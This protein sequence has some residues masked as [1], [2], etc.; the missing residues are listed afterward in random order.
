MC[1]NNNKCYT[2]YFLSD[3]Y[4]K[5]F[6]F[7]YFQIHHF[8]YNIPIY[9]IAINTKDNY[10]CVGQNIL[11]KQ[12]KQHTHGEMQIA[13]PNLNTCVRLAQDIILII[14]KYY[15]RQTYLF[16]NLTS[17]QLH[18]VLYQI[19]FVKFSYIFHK[20]IVVHVKLFL[21]GFLYMSCVT[22]QNTSSR[23]YV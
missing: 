18:V 5:P 6:F 14:R 23:C 16:F 3:T 20:L 21:S 22:L 10:T 17:E 13:L 19:I 12:Q 8:G 4:V 2:C 11:I 7:N 9:S 1:L 15:L